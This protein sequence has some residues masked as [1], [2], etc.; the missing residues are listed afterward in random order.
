MSLSVPPPGAVSF[1]GLGQPGRYTLCFAENEA[2]SPWMP[3]HAEA[4]LAADASAVTVTRAETVI[5]V[6]GGLW[7]H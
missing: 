6:T 3:L 7:M 2:Q 5:N 1:A 4:G